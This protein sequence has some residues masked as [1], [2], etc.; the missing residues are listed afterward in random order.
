MLGSCIHKVNVIRFTGDSLVTTP[1]TFFECK[2]AEEV[3][4]KTFLVAKI[5]RISHA[6]WSG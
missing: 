4:K 5:L 1:I 3:E 6:T 2:A